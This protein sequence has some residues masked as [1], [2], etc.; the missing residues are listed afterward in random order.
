MPHPPTWGWTHDPQSKNLLLFRQL[1]GHSKW[2][3]DKT[4]KKSLD[5]I[6]KLWRKYDH[7]HRFPSVVLVVAR[8]VGAR[9]LGFVK[10]AEVSKVPNSNISSS[11]LKAVVVSV[12]EGWVRIPLLT[13]I[14]SSEFH[15]LIKISLSSFKLGPIH[16]WVTQPLKQQLVFGMK[17]K[18]D[19]M[20]IQML[21]RVQNNSF[22][23]VFGP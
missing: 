1:A 22:K 9:P 8:H 21:N 6:M 15:D 2:R 19:K 16:L 13:V 4:R 12:F 3:A 14:L 18:V 7:G 17:M 20:R 23:T 11:L 10:M 5:Q